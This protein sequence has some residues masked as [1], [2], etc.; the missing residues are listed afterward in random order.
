MSAPKTSALVTEYLARL[1]QQSGAG[2]AN[3]LAGF[4][5]APIGPATTVI[6]TSGNFTTVNGRVLVLAFATVNTD[7]AGKRAVYQLIRDAGTAIG[8]FMSSATVASDVDII[9]SG[10]GAWV[11]VVTPGSTHKWGIK[12]TSLVSLTIPVGE[13][14]IVLV[15]L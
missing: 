4:N 6:H 1:A 12:I 3:Q 8:S 13:A 9:G 15:D 2:W 5:G 10:F 7:A 14:T 11:D